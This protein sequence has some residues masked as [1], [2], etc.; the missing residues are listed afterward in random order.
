MLLVLSRDPQ[1]RISQARTVD[2]GAD[3]PDTSSG[4]RED[5]FEAQIHKA[6]NHSEK[7]GAGHD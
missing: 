3:F 6:L 7:T 1:R 5:C 2:C 4:R